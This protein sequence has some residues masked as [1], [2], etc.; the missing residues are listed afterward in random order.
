MKITA[1]N[2]VSNAMI[3]FL[4]AAITYITYNISF[5][6]RKTASIHLLEQSKLLLLSGK[7]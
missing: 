6:E 5:S 3:C 2:I 1:R 7:F 4:Y